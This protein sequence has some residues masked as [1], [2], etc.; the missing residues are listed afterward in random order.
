LLDRVIGHALQLTNVPLLGQG[1]ACPRTRRAT[2]WFPFCNYSETDTTPSTRWL[3]GC[4]ALDAQG[5]IKTGSDLS[6]E[7]LSAAKWPLSRPPQLS[8]PVGPGCLRWAM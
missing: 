3:E 1:P 2:E 7:E 8:K 5:F 4:I 6:P